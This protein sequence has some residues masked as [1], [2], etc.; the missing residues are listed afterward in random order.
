VSDPVAGSSGPSGSFI[1]FEGGEGSGK[2]T[3]AALLAEA[4]DAH[5]TREPGGTPLGGALRGLLLGNSELSPTDVTEALLMAADRAQHVSEV[6]RPT[7]AEGR[8]VVCDRYV[9]SSVA[10]QGHGRGLGADRIAELSRW[11]TGGLLAD[12]VVL[13]DVDEQTAAGRTGTPRD[14]IEAAGAEFHRRV[15]AGFLAQA[16]ADPLRWIVLDGAGTV[17]AVHEEVV[18]SLQRRLGVTVKR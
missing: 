12:L 10:Y 7:L 1:V 11:A 3:Q 6:I 14:R 4:I 18:V 9:G 15:R 5:L 17:E 8:H 2:S 16:E 13:L